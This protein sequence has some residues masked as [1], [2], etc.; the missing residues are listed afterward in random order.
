VPKVGLQPD[1]TRATDGLEALK[2]QGIYPAVAPVLE[3]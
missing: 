1:A 3:S 2:I